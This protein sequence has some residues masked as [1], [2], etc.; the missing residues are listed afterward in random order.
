MTPQQRWKLKNRERYL[1]QAREYM[2]TRY[3]DNPEV[4]A[5]KHEYDAR[6]AS[7]EGRAKKRLYYAANRER[8]CA[9]YRDWNANRRARRVN[10]FIEP[11]DRLVLFERDAGLCGICK[12][13]V[14]P[15]FQ[16]DHVVP[17]A[18]GGEHSYAN[19]QVA[20]PVCNNRKGARI[21]N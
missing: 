13:P 21:I 4:R 18:K 2:N 1:A 20:H 8:L 14:G 6:R 9:K 11:V 15:D 3:R 17:L 7:E 10:Q 16:V 5:R 12:E 19:T